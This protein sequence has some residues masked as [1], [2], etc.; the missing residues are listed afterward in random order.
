MSG[1]DKP[2]ESDSDRTAAQTTS[3]NECLLTYERR[4]QYNTSKNS[5]SEWCS[6]IIANRDFDA[7]I[8][9]PFPVQQGSIINQGLTSI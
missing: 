3:R 4:T 6:D 5:M 1:K 8:G 9:S 7:V 2:R